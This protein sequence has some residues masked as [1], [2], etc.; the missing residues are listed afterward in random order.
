M[1]L[2]YDQGKHKLQFV[3]PLAKQHREN[4]LSRILKIVNDYKIFAN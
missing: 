4:K 3:S 2:Q 1:T